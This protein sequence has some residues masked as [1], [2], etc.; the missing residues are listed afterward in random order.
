MGMLKFKE[1]SV[2]LIN[3]AYGGGF[4]GANNN[5]VDL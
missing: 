1:Y 2:Q 5:S 4:S 3:A